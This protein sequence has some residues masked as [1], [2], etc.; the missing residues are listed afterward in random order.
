MTKDVTAKQYLDTRTVS[1]VYEAQV[2]GDGVEKQASI[3]SG[4]NARQPRA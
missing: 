1:G 4:A 2:I 3:A